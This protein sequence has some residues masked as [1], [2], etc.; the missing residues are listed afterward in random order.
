MRGSQNTGRGGVRGAGERSSLRS[1][2][3]GTGAMRP[4]SLSEAAKVHRAADTVREKVQAHYEKHREQWVV[5]Q[6][7]R[8]LAKSAPTL[9][10]HPPGMAVDPKIALMQRATKE[11]AHRHTQRLHRIDKARNSM[12]TGSAM[13]QSRK[14]EWGAVS[15]KPSSAR[16]ANQNIGARPAVQP[17]RATIAKVAVAQDR[18]RRKAEAHLVKHQEKWTGTRYNKLASAFELSKVKLSE[19]EAQHVRDAAM[20][21]ANR[22]VAA[23]HESRLQRIDA[24]C[25]RMRQSGNVRA[26]RPMGRNLGLGE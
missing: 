7:G 15:A 12:L 6:Y 4:S 1:N 3:K 20:D 23:K 14:I 16:A 2:F 11:V 18:A 5:R 19:R 10:L 9:T 17:P 22:S 24:V 25:D 21:A 8:L 26:S 13:R